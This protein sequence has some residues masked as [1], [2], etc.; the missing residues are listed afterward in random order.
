M[1]VDIVHVL[2]NEILE[3]L[4][5]LL[6]ILLRLIQ[7]Y[8]SLLFE[9]HSFIVCFITKA[10]HAWFKNYLMQKL[11]IIKGFKICISVYT[12]DTYVIGLGDSEI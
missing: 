1:L 8:L 2:Q 4:A 12:V 7:P 6:A 9:K 3:V 10:M 5:I 11:L